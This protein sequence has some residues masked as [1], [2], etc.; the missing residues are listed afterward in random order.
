VSLWLA[1]LVLVVVGGVK[2]S[3]LVEVGLVGGR[4]FGL[5]QGRPILAI[6]GLVGA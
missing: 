5:V 4:C 6:F 3:Q 1:G 2:L